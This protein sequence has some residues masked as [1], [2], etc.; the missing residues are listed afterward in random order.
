MATA[1][2]MPRLG[3]TM[4]EGTVIEWHVQQGAVIE[5][6][7]VLLTVESE[8]TQVEVDAFASGVLA[9]IYVEAGTTLPVGA[10]LG[11]IAGPDEAFDAAAFAASFVPEAAETPATAEEP[12]TPRPA[13]AAGAARGTVKA[14]PA[15]RALA[16]RLG[17]DVD[18]IAGTGP[19]G[20]IIVEDVERAAGPRA[21]GVAFE[22]AGQ[23]SL[24][25]LVAGYGVDAS[26][27]RRQVDDLRSTHTVVTF[28]HRGIGAS[29][30]PAGAVTIA[31]LASDARDVLAQ[32][33]RGRAIVVGASMGA[34]VAL[35]LALEY[36]EVVRGLVLVTPVFEHDAR[37]EAVLRSWRDHETP[38]SETRIRAFLPWL[39]GREL[40][41]HPGRREA[42][43]G[44]L[45]TMATRT[46]PATLRAHADALLAWLGTRTAAAARVAVP[47]LVVAG[48]DDVLAP[49]A[50]AEAL[51]RAVQGARLE[52]LP[53]AGHALMIERAERLN[54]L[55]REFAA[56][57]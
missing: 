17:I 54:A 46:P 24:L 20:R 37:F 9:A 33:G 11:A 32:V 28:D 43:A 57:V 50:H 47:T 2:T 1:V 39:L 36:P 16:K 55:V 35:E 6:G 38:A 15:A 21:Q 48:G 22:V 4:A 8:K 3:L 30:P 49:P 31:A 45:R 53:G 40:L 18:A 34:A 44:A 42:A 52:V 27:W 7:A 41:V 29:A 12:A 5:K 51:A 10:L 23:G 19:G 25:L 56:A 26:S 14:A 13:I